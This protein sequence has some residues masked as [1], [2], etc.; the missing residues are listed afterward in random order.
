MQF[1]IGGQS[2]GEERGEEKH[3]EDRAIP[4]GVNNA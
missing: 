3:I 1:V 4:S 2:G